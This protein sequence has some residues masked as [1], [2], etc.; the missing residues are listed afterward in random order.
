VALPI[1]GIFPF[2]KKV[3]LS[4]SHSFPS[5]DEIVFGHMGDGNL[6][7]NVAGVDM[8]EASLVQALVYQCAVDCGGSLSAEHGIGAFRRE[9]LQKLTDPVVLDLMKKVKQVFDPHEILNP[10]KVLP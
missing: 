6:H 2:L 1:S 5:F 4:L 9:Q 7:Y 10:Q 8:K 3:R